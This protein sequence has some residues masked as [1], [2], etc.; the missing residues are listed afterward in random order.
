MDDLLDNLQGFRDD[1]L[2][3]VF[4]Q[5]TLERNRPVLVKDLTKLVNETQLAG[6]QP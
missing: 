6:N 3:L 1:T 2:S 4:A 5:D